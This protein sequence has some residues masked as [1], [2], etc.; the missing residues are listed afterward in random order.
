MAEDGAQE[1]AGRV[2]NYLTNAFDEVWNTRWTV[3]SNRFVQTFT[4]VCKWHETI[5]YPQ[6]YQD[7]HLNFPGLSRRH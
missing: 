1:T 5:G 2:S 7:R 3:M 6:D 4:N